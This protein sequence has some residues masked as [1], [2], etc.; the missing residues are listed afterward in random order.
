MSYLVLIICIFF[1]ALVLILFRHPAQ[2]QSSLR[3]LLLLRVKNS[4]SVSSSRVPFRSLAM[5]FYFHSFN[6]LTVTLLFLSSVFSL[7]YIFSDGMAIKCSNASCIRI[8]FV[9]RAVL[10][11]YFPVRVLKRWTFYKGT[12]EISLASS[13][14]RLKERCAKN[15]RQD[16]RKKVS[17]ELIAGPVDWELYVPLLLRCPYSISSQAL[18]GYP[19][20]DNKNRPESS[21][22]LSVH[23]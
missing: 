9:W 3:H 10:Q 11:V 7:S 6:V 20:V 15:R 5:L 23:F 19:Y 2:L 1:I 16:I 8:A 17:A 21:T 18:V 22:L 14:C 4:P 13:N 12:T